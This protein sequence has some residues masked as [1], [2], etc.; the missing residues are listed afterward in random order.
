MPKRFGLLKKKYCTIEMLLSIAEELHKDSRHWNKYLRNQW[1]EFDSNYEENIHRLYIELKH[2]VYKHG[3][4]YI[5]EKVEHGKLRR[6]YSSSPRDRIVDKLLSI[7]LEDVFLPIMEKNAFGSIKGRG[8]HKCR[9]LVKKAV[10]KYEYPYAAQSDISKYYPTCSPERILSIASKKIKCRWL[11]WLLEEFLSIGEVVLGNVSSNIIGHINM[12]E[13]DRIMVRE[14]G[15]KHYYRFCDD[16][17]V[18]SDDKNYLHTAMRE[19]IRLVAENKQKVKHTWAV[20]PLKKRRADFLG[21]TISTHDSKL[22]KKTRVRVECE[23][24]SLDKSNSSPDVVMR[25][26]AGMNGAFRG[27]EMSNLLKHWEHEY[28]EVFE[29]LRRRKAASIAANV[30]K[31][32]RA[33]VEAELRTARDCRSS[34]VRRRWPVS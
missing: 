1:S 3:E 8:Q 14:F 9:D 12:M 28:R 19:Y 13:I 2:Q 17:I 33:K 10:R 4:Y 27:I 20:F 26:W 31:R 24:K 15:F 29:R 30:A 21:M 25:K 16:M 32:R 5:F 6:I 11:L 22:R 18:I 34:D 23:L 7:A